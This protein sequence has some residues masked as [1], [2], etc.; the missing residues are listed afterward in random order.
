[1]AILDRKTK[2]RAKVGKVGL[3]FLDND[4]Y[5]KTLEKFLGQTITIVFQDTPYMPI[6]PDLYAFYFGI[7]IRQEMMSSE[8][9]KTYY[10]ENEIHLMLQAKLRTF[11]R[12]NGSFTD[13]VLQ[14]DQANFVIYVN[15]VILYLESEFG[16]VIN[17]YKTYHIDRLRLT[18]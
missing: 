12:K 13:N 18:R 14:Y 11:L 6:T 8:A 5:F 9:F 3:L 17:D 1:M 16:I 15:D 10:D 2:L 7:I 4:A